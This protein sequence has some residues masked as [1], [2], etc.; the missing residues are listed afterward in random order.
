MSVDALA[1]PEGSPDMADDHPAQAPDSGAYHTVEHDEAG[2]LGDR[3]EDAMQETTE[4]LR[5]IP[6]ASTI[7]SQSSQIL[8]EFGFPRGRKAVC[9]T[10]VVHNRPFDDAENPCGARGSDPSDCC[11]SVVHIRRQTVAPIIRPKPSGNGRQQPPSRSRRQHPGLIMRG[12]VFYLRLRVPRSLEET[13]GRT[14]VWRSLRTGDQAQAI[15]QARIVAYDF[16]RALLD[17]E[18]ANNGPISTPAQAPPM[19]VR[20]AAPTAP[21]I[22]PSC[23]KTFRDLYDLFLADASKERARTTQMIYD[24]LF[25]VVSGVWGA[26]KPLRSINREA[27][28][29]LLETLRWLPSNPTKRFPKLTIVEASRMA[30]TKGLTS[31]LS[32]GS[33][34]GYMNKLGSLLNYAVNEGWIERNPAKGLRVVDPVRRR[35]KRS[36]FSTEQLRLI[37]NAPLYRGCVDDEWHYAEPGPNQPRRG[38]F[39]VPLIALFSGMRLNEICQLDTDDIRSV[40]G[41]ARR[42]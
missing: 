14:H 19:P 5:T 39:W 17:A 12:R 4:E 35:D 31:I 9:C 33:V 1:T 3:L 2:S 23:E 40:D 11:T 22:R 36:P 29:D 30:K 16:E 8:T 10:N 26:D 28:R 32:P 27:C 34:N 21:L 13:V 18:G 15:R 42:N 41:V 24:N 6:V 38:R 25:A 20:A 7:F 37:F